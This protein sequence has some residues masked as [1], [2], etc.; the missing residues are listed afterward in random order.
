M[1]FFD[2]LMGLIVIQRIIIV[3]KFQSFDAKFVGAVK[4]NIVL[5]RSCERF[6]T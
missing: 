5:Y 1:K 3:E 6:R 4:K 2:D